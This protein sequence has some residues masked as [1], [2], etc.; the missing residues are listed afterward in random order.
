V[1]SAPL[2]PRPPSRVYVLDD[3]RIFVD[4]LLHYL[5]E[6]EGLEVVGA[7]PRGPQTYAQIAA[8]AP[9]VVVVDPGPRLESIAPT[10]SEVRQAVPRAAV[11]ALSFSYEEAYP[12]IAR[13]VGVDAYIDKL[14]AADDL[15]AA[16]YQVTQR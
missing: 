6:T 10:L 5:N 13:Q 11:I 3:H 4:I 2:A 7:G 8:L 9:D 12:A 14:A 1:S 16:I 15:I